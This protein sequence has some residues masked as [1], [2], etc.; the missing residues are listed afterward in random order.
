MASAQD[1]RKDLLEIAKT[2][3]SSPTIH[4]DIEVKL[5]TEGQQDSPGKQKILLRKNNNSFYYK[6]DKVEY[7][8]TEGKGI[9]VNHQA[10]TISYANYQKDTY[11]KLIKKISTAQMDTIFNHYDSIKYHGIENNKKHYTIFSSQFMVSKTEVYINPERN[12]LTK[13]SYRYNPQFT[14]EPYTVEMNFTFGE[15][16][17]EQDI[18]LF[19][20]TRYLLKNGSSY[21][22]ADNFKNY[23][24]KQIRDEDF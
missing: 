14:G 2:W 6:V 8:F 11:Q 5:Y 17:T 3:Q 23:Q 13:L 12:T 7:L 9:V 4:M 10:A 21:R 15:N 1:L 18:I 22:I 24:L 19:A 16:L 20:E